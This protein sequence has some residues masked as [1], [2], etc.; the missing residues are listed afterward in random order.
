[1][2]KLIK[3]YRQIFYLAFLVAI[4]VAIS[5]LGSKQNKDIYLQVFGAEIE[6][7][8]N[9]C[10]YPEDGE[11]YL[12]LDTVRQYIDKD[13]FYDKI[14][15]Q[16]NVTSN[17]QILKMKVGE[18]KASLNYKSITTQQVLVK[19]GNDI[20]I[21]VSAIKEIY[22]IDGI[23][24][25]NEKIYVVNNNSEK[26]VIK[27]N[28]ISMYSKTNVT[29]EVN[30]KLSKNEKVTV[31]YNLLQSD[32]IFVK[33]EKGQA[34]YIN[35][36]NLSKESINKLYAGQNNLRVQADKETQNSKANKLNCI[37][38]SDSID[39]SGAYKKNGL[40]NI[41]IDMF[42]VLKINGGVDI[43]G[44]SQKWLVA[45][46][47]MGYKIYGNVTN[48]YNSSNFDNTV[49]ATVISNPDTRDKL[50]TNMLK[51][52]QEYKLN[53]LIVDF[54]G[55]K[56]SD[57]AIYIQFL[58][59]FGTAMRGKNKKLLVKT[60]MDNNTADISKALEYIDY[61]I[62]EGYNHR[63]IA[64]NISGT[65][66]DINKIKKDIDSILNT[67][68]D[69]YAS[70]VILELPIYSILWEEKNSKVIDSNIY[71][72]KATEEYIT[73]NKLTKKLDSRTNQNYVELTK[74][75][76]VYKM[77]VEDEYSLKEKIK[78]VKDK[79]LAG[80][81]IYRAGYDSDNLINKILK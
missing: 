35:K 78:I 65:D 25:D 48:G 1:M 69:E 5:C 56:K 77:W 61:C 81:V 53:G 68:N 26:V 9:K 46:K 6:N 64:S 7:V 73:K 62:I 32:W 3:R 2:A 42:E 67:N 40:E 30:G 80:V 19:R 37:V 47:N 54:K 36:Y 76:I 59:E 66:S 27:N 12:S 16:L 28:N 38:Y 49:I 63:N 52:V 58:K 13:I 60:T 57:E 41:V 70:K 72:Q 55:I 29:S 4:I 45:A 44:T 50:I 15:R 24:N 11:I 79:N 23:N 34:G 43:T 75:S 39:V 20:Y 18:N 51:K 10:V 74:G 33:N 17:G 22:G 21:P 31:Y 14:A 71:S 8:D